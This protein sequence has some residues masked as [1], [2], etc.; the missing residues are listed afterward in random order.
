MAFS[1][2]GK[3]ME[4]DIIIIVFAIRRCAGWASTLITHKHSPKEVSRRKPRETQKY[5]FVISTPKAH[6]IAHVE[7]WWAFCFFNYFYGLTDQP[8]DA[9]ENKNKMLQS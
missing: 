8:E 6:D 7:A 5:W 1:R 2:L 3:P 9:N 4:Y